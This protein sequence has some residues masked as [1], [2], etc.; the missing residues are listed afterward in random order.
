M[1]PPPFEE[2]ELLSLAYAEYLGSARWAYA[3]VGWP[4]VLQR[5]SLG[6][7]DL[8]LGPALKAITFHENYLPFRYDYIH[9]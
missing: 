3:R 8:P 1:N 5:Y 9:H 2:A 4:T 7:L 6:V